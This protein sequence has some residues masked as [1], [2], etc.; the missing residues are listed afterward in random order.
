MRRSNCLGAA[1]L[2]LALTACDRG[3][4]TGGEQ[5]TKVQI[6]N[7]YQDR[8]MGLSVLNRSLGLRRAIQG[9]GQGCTRIIATAYQAP[10]KGQHQWIGRCEPE[11]DYA[12]FIAPNGDAQV[13]KCTD[14]QTLGLPACK[15]DGLDPVPRIKGG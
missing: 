13:R 2:M 14:A 4:G 11:G 15:Q 10:Y 9:A 3:G 12:I 5:A 1:A 8:L 7:P 6:A